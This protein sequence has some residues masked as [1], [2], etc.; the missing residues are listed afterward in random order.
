[1]KLQKGINTKTNREIYYIDGNTFPIRKRLGKRGVGFNYFP[2]RK[3]WWIYPEYLTEEKI[4]KLNQLDIDTSILSSDS[5]VSE[6]ERSTQQFQQQSKQQGEQEHQEQQ[7]EL[8]NKTDYDTEIGYKRIP[9]SKWYGFPI[10]QNIYSTNFEVEVDSEK[11]PIK[12]VL[13]R[14]YKKGRRKIPSYIYH[15]YYNDKLVGNARVKSKEK[16]GEYNE[17][18]IAADIPE[19]IQKAIDEKG[20][21][22]QSL[23]NLINKENRDP[24]FKEFIKKWDDFSFDPQKEQ[25]FLKRYID[26]PV[27]KI[28]EGPYQGTYPIRLRKV[29]DGI[30]LHTYVD[31]PLA[32]GSERVTVIN[33]PSEIQNIDQFQEYV[34]KAINENIDEIKTNYIEYLKSFPYLQEE[35]SK[36]RELMEQLISM[37]GK[38]YNVNFFKNKLESLGYIRPSKKG[39]RKQEGFIPRESIKWVLNT[40]KILNDIY[41][42]RQQETMTGQDPKKFFAIIAYWLHRKVKNIHSFSEFMLMWEIGRW[43]TLAKRYGYDI[44]S[45]AIVDYF[46]KVSNL[47]YENLYGEKHKDPYEDMND[48]YQNYYNRQKGQEQEGADANSL[49]PFAQYA[50]ELGADYQEALNTP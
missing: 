12:V 27:I 21:V 44:D 40:D 19:K 24:E 29:F 36:H 42:N 9:S 50:Q 7:E 41:G 46:N 2:P 43:E 1:M 3:M 26:I 45:N 11:I 30:H 31:H 37:V 4:K 15:I 8:T 23:Q 22:Y 28:S 16:W 39:K 49:I 13:D 6:N 48:F 38:N 18:K 17:D 20:R 47:L 14:W 33:F 35:E 34:N 5:S 25:N 32:P 10:K